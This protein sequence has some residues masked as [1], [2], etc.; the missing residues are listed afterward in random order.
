MKS[1]MKA[2]LWLGFGGGVG[3][4]VGYNVGS[5]H[6]DEIEEKKSKLRP[7]NVDESVVHIVRE[8]E[9]QNAMDGY[10]GMVAVEDVDLPEGWENDPLTVNC[11]I[12]EE[13]AQSTESEV[14]TSIPYPITEEEFN[15][16]D[17][18]YDIKCLDY[19]EEDEVVYDPE[20]EEIVCNSDDIL[21]TGWCSGFYGD[22]NNP[23]EVIYI[24]NNVYGTLYRVELVHAAF[25]EVVPGSIPPD[26]DDPD[27][28]EEDED[29]L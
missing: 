24:Q 22:P 3:F 19:Y 2:L 7:N 25:N 15:F 12:S 17:N 11:D 23:T 20:F 14:D 10:R 21:G 13:T 28:C 6:G 16:N 29:I 26:D 9:A 18:G 27:P 8:E 1:W 5:K 4:F